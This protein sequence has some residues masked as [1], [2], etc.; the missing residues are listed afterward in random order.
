MLS[1]LTALFLLASPDAEAASPAM[2]D[3]EAASA[4]APSQAIQERARMP[5]PAEISAARSAE[6]AEKAARAAQSAAESAAKLAAA[7]E[8]LAASL[9]ATKATPDAGPAA[10]PVP[11]KAQKAQEKAATWS[12]I[13]G[14]SLISLTG[15]A[16]SIT[17][18]ANAALRRESKRWIFELKASGAYGRTRAADAIDEATGE[19]VEVDPE[20]V[21]LNANV[22][23]RADLRFT[24]KISVYLLGGVMTDHVK[25][26]ETRPVGEAGMSVI[27][28]DQKKGDVSTLRLQTDF[29]F[30][31]GK[32]LRFQYYPEP[33]N[34]EDQVIAAPRF[35]L[36]LRYAMTEG[37][38]LTEDFEVLPNVVGDSRVWLSS[39]TKISVKLIK[40]LSFSTSFL[41]THDTAPA[42]GKEKTD[43][44]L[45]V[46]LELAF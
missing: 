44:A 18:S 32:E 42:E 35:A 27:W 19:L 8:R 5:A 15:N 25:S 36:A 13:V 9:E 39:L 12:G 45:T 29:A 20:I 30:R 22:D 21:A 46:G 23:L 7:F 41:V 37:L 10:A 4:S 6:A 34:P 3:L 17:T 43:T 14:L 24:S 33:A 26:I 28:L 1:V 2:V 38:I 11:P 40:A 16:N 31:G